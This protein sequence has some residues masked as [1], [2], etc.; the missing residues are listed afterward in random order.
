[1]DVVCHNSCRGEVAQRRLALARRQ[2]NWSWGIP[3]NTCAN[4]G[5]HGIPVN[6]RHEQARVGVVGCS[7]CCVKVTRRLALVLRNQKGRSWGA[8]DDA[9]ANL[10]VRG[11]TMG[12]CH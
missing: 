12:R 3:Y 7:S 9:Y 5:V 10:G 11:V 8:P 6:R 1:M 2:R 4:F